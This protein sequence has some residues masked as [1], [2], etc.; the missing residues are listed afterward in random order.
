MDVKELILDRIA[1]AE[2]KLHEAHLKLQCTEEAPV[3][4]ITAAAIEAAAKSAATFCRD[5]A[6]IAKTLKRPYA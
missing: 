2:K 5:L 3:D 6:A 1:S 4:P